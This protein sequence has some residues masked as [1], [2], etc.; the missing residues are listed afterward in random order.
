MTLA[1]EDLQA[2]SNIVQTQVGELGV[3]LDSRMDG[4]ETR[5]EGIEARMEGIETR[6]DN[7]ETK[8]LP[9]MQGDIRT[10]QGEIQTMKG[11]IQVMQGDIHTMQDETQTMKGDIRKTQIIMENDILPPLRNI[12]NCYTTTFWRY[13]KKS[14]Q[15]EAM[16]MDVDVLKDAVAEHS[17][18]LKKIS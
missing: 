8:I 18:Q 2:I 14:D 10:M 3:H 12:E 17:E 5:M 16:Q 13:V 4:I 9:Q 11:D 7:I 15:I 6:V 1:R